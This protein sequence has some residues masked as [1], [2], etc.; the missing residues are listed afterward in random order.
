[1]EEHKVD[2]KMI[3]VDVRFGDKEWSVPIGDFRLWL[4]T[5]IGSVTLVLTKTQFEKKV[6]NAVDKVIQRIIDTNGGL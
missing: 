6:I 5:E 1:M 4:T 3:Y 2:D